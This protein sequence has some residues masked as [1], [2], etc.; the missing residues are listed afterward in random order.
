MNF[1]QLIQDY[2]TFNRNERKGII[3]LV[4]IIFMLAVANKIVFYFETPAKIDTGLLLTP[5]AENPLV[6]DP[7]QVAVKQ[8]HLFRFDPNTIDR[9][10]LDSLLLPEAIKRNI[11]KYREKGGRYYTEN[12]FRKMY[13]VTDSIFSR[14]KPFLAIEK[15]ESKKVQP[16]KVKIQP[17]LFAFDPNKASDHEFQ[18]LGLSEKQVQTIRNYQSKGGRFRNKADFSKIYGISASQKDALSPFVKIGEK[19]NS[20]PEKMLGVSIT[21]I[22]INV[23]DS[24]ELMTLPGIGNILSKRIVKYRDLLGGYYSVTQLKEVYGLSEA[25]ILKIEGM[26]HIDSSKLHRV[27][28]N[29]ADWNELA[30]HPYL[31]KKLASKIVKFRTRYGSIND[32]SVLRDSM[33]LSIEEYNRLKPYL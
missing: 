26:I 13:G 32:P 9:S 15:F 30:K 24:I 22:E 29:F 7:D 21:P 20:N 11:L 4:V 12:D 8:H 19:E 2:F 17:E 28:L 16:A 33:I 1:R 3:I 31:Q 10:A 14:V 6:V 23:A 27:D 18:R 25:T 5:L